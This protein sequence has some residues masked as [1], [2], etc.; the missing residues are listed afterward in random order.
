ML[1]LYD[2]LALLFLIPAYQVL[3]GNSA[4]HPTA[5]TW[6]YREGPNDYRRV[7]ADADAVLQGVRR[8]AAGSPVVQ[9]S[10]TV[11]KHRYS[12]TLDFANKTFNQWNDVTRVQRPLLLMDAY[13]SFLG[14]AG[15]WELVP[16]WAARRLEVALIDVATVGSVVRVE[17]GSFTYEIDVVAM[18][19]RNTK[20]GRERQ[21]RRKSFEDIGVDVMDDATQ[22]PGALPP[23]AVPL[24]SSSDTQTA[25]GQPVTKPHFAK[26]GKSDAKTDTRDTLLSAALNAA[27]AGAIVGTVI[28]LVH[29]AYVGY[30]SDGSVKEIIFT[31]VSEAGLPIGVWLITEL[32]P[33]VIG[34]FV[35][36]IGAIVSGAVELGAFLRHV[37]RCVA[38][39]ITPAALW[40][41]LKKFLA[42]SVV[43]IAL[44]IGTMVLL[45]VF[46][47]GC[48]PL[49]ASIAAVSVASTAILGYRLLADDFPVDEAYDLLGCGTRDNIGTVRSRA[50]TLLDIAATK[51][52]RVAIVAAFHRI[53]CSRNLATHGLHLLGG[54]PGGYNH[55]PSAFDAAYF[56]TI[57]EATNKNRC[58]RGPGGILARVDQ[59]GYPNVTYSSII[60]ASVVASGVNK[61][62][63]LSQSD[64][65]FHNDFLSQ[66]IEDRRLLFGSK[67]VLLFRGGQRQFQEKTVADGV[68]HVRPQAQALGRG[69]YLTDNFHKASNYCNSDASPAEVVVLSGRKYHRLFLVATVVEIAHPA[70]VG[71]QAGVKAS[72]E[73]TS[74]GVDVVI[75]PRESAVRRSFYSHNEF[76]VVATPCHALPHFLVEVLAAQ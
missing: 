62:P 22:P 33:V 19:Q 53:C 10:Y 43:P 73:H 70:I 36:L 46:A 3:M 38:G 11:G 42:C 54:P 32:G 15:E 67:H 34:Q 8:K 57:F 41:K 27:R 51:P 21:L 61:L 9:V 69:L 68:F 75:A 59:P 18:N 29:S 2:T 63:Q 26:G 35:P 31:F 12:A 44:S 14:D 55:Y 52:V 48:P 76:C 5:P 72:H 30:F 13:W 71:R 66:V 4:S 17:I 1:L 74:N 7:H 50:N 20:T 37:G 49:L 60:V 23:T 58:P 40:D 24:P 39:T 64:S 25:T 16:P 65:G 45:A 47:I 28:G 6:Y 56:K